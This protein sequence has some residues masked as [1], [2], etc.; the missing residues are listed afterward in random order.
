[1]GA[2]RNSRGDLPCRECD[3]TGWV[4]Y[5]AETTDGGFEGAYRLCP[6]GC[7]PRYCVGSKDDRHCPRP[8]TVRR[9]RGYH[10]GEHAAY[11]PR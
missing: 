11:L 5:R 2:N 6:G 1:V 9:R 8:A 10:C 7:A 4:P 3:G